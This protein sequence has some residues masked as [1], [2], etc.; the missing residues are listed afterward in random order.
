M[1]AHVPLRCAHSLV[2]RS[3]NMTAVPGGGMQIEFCAVVSSTHVWHS[4]AVDVASCFAPSLLMSR[5]R[6]AALPI[7]SVSLGASLLARRYLL[8]RT[9]LLPRP[10]PRD[11][12]AAFVVPAAATTTD[13]VRGSLASPT[14]ARIFAAF[15]R[16]GMKSSAPVVRREE[17]SV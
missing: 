14:R 8:S 1:T 12:A 7:S 3:W 16:R 2:V 10:C 9:F 11:V 4:S 6:P 5:A 15:L 17:A 13:L